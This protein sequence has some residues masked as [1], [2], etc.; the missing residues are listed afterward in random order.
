MLEIAEQ[1]L[2]PVGGVEDRASS[3]GI[4]SLPL[5]F[6]VV[7]EMTWHSVTPILILAK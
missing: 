5:T 6:K 7:Q 4:V 3:K 1:G 2:M